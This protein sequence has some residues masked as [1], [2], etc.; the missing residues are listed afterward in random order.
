MTSRCLSVLSVSR[1]TYSR[2]SNVPDQGPPRV[3]YS[4]SHHDYYGPLQGGTTHTSYGVSQGS[5]YPQV[6]Q[7]SS[8][9]LGTPAG[10]DTV[11]HASQPPPTGPR[12]PTEF[13]SIDLVQSAGSPYPL[14]FIHQHAGSSSQDTP[15]A[16]NPL[17]GWH[18][19][20]PTSE[21]H[22]PYNP[23]GFRVIRQQNTQ[24]VDGAPPSRGP[25]GVQDAWVPISPSRR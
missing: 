8:L 21:S 16:W 6:L 7:S 4:S 2:D 10:Y 19:H 23:G 24:P 14:G 25:V 1:P 13:V 12:P 20:Q 22:S 17:A 11:P 9:Q 15:G 18:S 3:D 5:M